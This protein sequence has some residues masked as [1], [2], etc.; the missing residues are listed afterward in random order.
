MENSSLFINSFVSWVLM[1][2]SFFL[3]SNL[4]KLCRTL[5]DQLSELKT[6][7]DENVRQLND[8]SAQKARLQTE[9]GKT[10]VTCSQPSPSSVLFDLHLLMKCDCS[11]PTDRAGCT[12][13][14]LA[15]VNLRLTE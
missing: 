1:C 3:Q 11:C 2:H 14:T 12:L 15:H 13:D 9:N 4:E 7:N 10:V 6:K 5:E 8:A